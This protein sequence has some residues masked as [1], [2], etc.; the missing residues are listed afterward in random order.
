MALIYTVPGLNNS[1]SSHWQTQW[2]N[3]NNSIKRIQ[4]DNWSNP[5][6]IS[7]TKRLSDTI[8]P[9]KAAETIL[10]GHSVGCSTI[11]H[12]YMQ[13]NLTLKGA[14]LVAPSDVDQKDY[15]KYITGFSPMPLKLLPFPTIVVASSN[16]HVVSLDRARFFSQ[17]WGSKFIQIE[18]AGHIEEKSGF[19]PWEE[20]LK[21]L[22][23]LIG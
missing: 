22:E 2:E 10:I 9:N 19:G 3:K 5:D 1:S 17:Q 16:D 6:R 20:G 8:D 21:L 23:E 14:L 11:V 4:Q 12:W 18:N 13:S 15:P 7:W